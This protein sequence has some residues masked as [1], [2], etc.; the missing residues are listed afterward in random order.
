MFDQFSNIPFLSNSC[1]F[2]KIL[3]WK[4]IVMIILSTKMKCECRI[5]LGFWIY[6]RLNPPRSRIAQSLSYKNEQ[7]FP[8]LIFR[9]ESRTRYRDYHSIDWLREL[10]RD[11][12][13]RNL[14]ENDRKSGRFDSKCYSIF[15]K[16]SGWL[17][18]LLIGI[19][20]GVGAG[21][22]DITT[23]WLS[24]LKLGVCSESIFLNQG[25]FWS[26]GVLIWRSYFRTVLLG[27]FWHWGSW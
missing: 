16:C 18:V 3:E 2:F 12:Q 4:A 19:S 7:N 24:D 9:K 1:F 20:A 5:N 8:N 27:W 23:K 10:S 25:T 17:V 22:V 6:D 21:I 11:R 13:R 26:H 15:D 14:I